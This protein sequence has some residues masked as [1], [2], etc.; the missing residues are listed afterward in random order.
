MTC[1]LSDG[2]LENT[3]IVIVL[4]LGLELDIGWQ[5]AESTF[6]F[7]FFGLE[8]KVFSQTYFY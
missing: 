5:Y 7:L 2:K 6:G 4:V 1:Y 3:P 8:K